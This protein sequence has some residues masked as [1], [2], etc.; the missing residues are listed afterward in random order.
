MT[1]VFYSDIERALTNAPDEFANK[2]AVLDFL[3]KNRIKKSEV[4]DYQYT[5]L[6]KLYDDNDPI[7]KATD[8]SQVRTA[9]ISGLRVHATGQGSDIINPNGAVDTRYTGY[10]ETWFYS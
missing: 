5:V 6:L 8:F 10:A 3:N 1:S 2:Q 7:H 9:P 4:E